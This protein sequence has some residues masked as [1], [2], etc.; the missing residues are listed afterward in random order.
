MKPQDIVV[1]LSITLHEPGSWKA[2]DLAQD[3]VISQAEIG[4]SLKRSVQCGLL[5][6]GREVMRISLLELLRYGIRFMFPAKPGDLVR[7]TPTAH[8]APPL[9]KRIMSD[10]PVVWPNPA[11]KVRGAAIAPL[12]PTVPKAVINNKPL[13]ELLALTDVLRIGRARERELALTELR[14]RLG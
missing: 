14:K 9:D 10:V 1:L 5:S 13:Y 3:L 8:S 6:E 12:Y 11:G 2:K 7:G 4:Y